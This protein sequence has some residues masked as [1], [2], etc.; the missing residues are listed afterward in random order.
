MTLKIKYNQIMENIKVTEE[1]HD[2]MIK[3]IDHTNFYVNQKKLIN[4]ISYKKYMAIAACFILL[5]VSAVVLP[6]L[7]KSNLNPPV[8]QGGNDMV[9]YATIGEL[10]D[11]VGFSIPQINKIPFAVKQ[12]T[13]TA[14][15]KELGESNY[16]N[17]ENA[18]IFRK[19]VGKEENSGNYNEYSNIKDVL[20]N[21]H[22]ITIKGDS[23]RFYL[24]IWQNSGY[25]YS[26]Q[27]SDGVSEDEMLEMLKSIK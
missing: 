11:A 5:V 18:I 9:E 13:F 8:E 1:I 21:K 22:K 10:S 14:Y 19:S 26:L 4:P 25:S 6:D 7:L 27:S 23:N 16:R 20:I 2:R 15:G 3:N 12:V 24:A 17:N